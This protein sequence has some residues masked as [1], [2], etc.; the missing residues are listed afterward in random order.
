MNCFRSPNCLFEGG[1]AKRLSI[2]S[3]QWLKVTAYT[4]HKK[5]FSV[6]RIRA[7]NPVAQLI[8]MGFRIIIEELDTEICIVTI[9]PI[10]VG[11]CDLECLVASGHK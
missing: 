5:A 3:F 6:I 4:G 10:S 7:R 8:I 9:V 11:T 2:L 1:V